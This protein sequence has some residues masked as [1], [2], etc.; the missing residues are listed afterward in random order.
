MPPL[1]C[2][3]VRAEGPG[4]S[5]ARRM[6]RTSAAMARTSVAMEYSSQST[7]P[8]TASGASQTASDRSQNSTR[9][10]CHGV[11]GRASHHIAFVHEAVLP[12]AR[13]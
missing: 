12:L 13:A 11:G 8:M 9:S 5:T 4:W 10:A 2:P 3:C 6:A 7:Q 1:S